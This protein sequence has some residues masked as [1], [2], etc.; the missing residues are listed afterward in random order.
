MDD[1]Q[2]K[3]KHPGGRPTKYKREYCQQMVDFCAQ[4]YSIT[5]FAGHIGVSRDCLS[6]WGAA[7]PEFFLAIKKSK[8]IAAAKFEKIAL[9]QLE[10]ELTSGQAL[11]I[12]MLKNY[13][14]NDFKDDHTLRLANE[15][16]K[17]FAITTVERTFVE[18]DNPNG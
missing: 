18:A 1:I 15:G 13:A 12:F 16:D 10:G 4:G 2:E 8:S 7:N 17:P 11:T 6:D 5:A 3:P 9:R 14:P